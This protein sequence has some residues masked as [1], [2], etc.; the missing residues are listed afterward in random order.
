MILHG[1]DSLLLGYK[2]IIMAFCFHN[3]NRSFA[4]IL[5]FTMLTYLWATMKTM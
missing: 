4:V 1:S 3:F 2:T 5:L